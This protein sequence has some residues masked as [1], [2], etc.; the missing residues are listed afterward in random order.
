MP[1]VN[2]KFGY[3]SFHI[4]FKCVC[5]IW[6][7]NGRGAMNP[8]GHNN[9]RYRTPGDALTRMNIIWDKDD[10]PIFG[11]ICKGENQNE[12]L[13]RR[14]LILFPVGLA[15]SSWRLTKWNLFFGSTPTTVD[16]LL[17]VC[18]VLYRII[19]RQHWPS[20]ESLSAQLSILKVTMDPCQSL[21]CAQSKCSASLAVFARTRDPDWTPLQLTIL[22][23]WAR[24]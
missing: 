1:A 18:L 14:C 8:F 6:P 22:C 9:L 2:S 15:W 5:G 7:Q 11:P 17:T 19:M 4:C 12:T 23:S 16:L 21:F 13:S 24:T 20:N 3:L 10:W